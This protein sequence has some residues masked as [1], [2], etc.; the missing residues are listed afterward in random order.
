MWAGILRV[1]Y[2]M[3]EIGRAVF[4]GL[5][6]LADG[7]GSAAPRLLFRES[8]LGTSSLRNWQGGDRVVIEF[9]AFD[10]GQ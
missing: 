1:E 10:G 2:Y 9:A 6:C 5:L 8:S 7:A 4:G 3:L